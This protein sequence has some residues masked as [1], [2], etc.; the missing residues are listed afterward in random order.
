QYWAAGTTRNQAVD[1]DL[2]TNVPNPFNIKNLT[3][4]QQSDPK[5][6]QYLSTQSFFTATT[7]RKNSLLRAFPQMNGLSGLRPG[8][9]YG[10]ALGYLW[11]HDLQVQFE[12][13]FSRGFQ[14]S[15]LY[16]YAASDTTDYYLNEFDTQ[17]S[18][19][20]NNNIRPHRFVWSSIYE[21]PF[22]KGRQFLTHGPLQHVAGGWQLSWVYQYQNGPATGWSTN[23]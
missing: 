10:D 17:L 14:T 19:R 6:Y 23:R 3:V 13:R 9:N 18:T 5:L 1:D 8:V 11:Y 4:L 21:L 20:P 16:T 15:V 2:Q 22:G 7:I 12:R